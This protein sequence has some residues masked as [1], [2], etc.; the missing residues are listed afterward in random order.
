ME[1][2]IIDMNNKN[3]CK[4]DIDIKNLFCY[5]AGQGKKATKTKAIYLNAKGLY[6]K[7]DHA[8]KQV[9]GMQKAL[10][11]NK[12]R[13]CYQM[14]VSFPKSMTD[15]NMVII[16]AEAIAEKIFEEHQVYY[17]VHGDTDNLHIHYAINAV[18]YNDGLKWHQSKSEFNK[19]KR[20][21]LGITNENLV[22][23]GYSKLRLGEKEV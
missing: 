13:R 18:S 6:K 22:T 2:L 19:F 20:Q 8:A 10:E 7:Y 3:H 21:I 14:V 4:R 1:T 17:G 9:I 15:K 11:K 12:G 5:I 16:I 23:Y